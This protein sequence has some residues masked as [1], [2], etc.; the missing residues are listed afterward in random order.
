MLAKLQSLTTPLLNLMER[1]RV[2]NIARKQMLAADEIL[3]MQ[4]R[5]APASGI[6]Q[7][8][9]SIESY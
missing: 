3:D 9:D 2:Q 4:A 6:Q 7:I 5:N 8:L 1:Q